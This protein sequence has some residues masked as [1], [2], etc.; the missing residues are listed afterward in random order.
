MY[1]LQLRLVVNIIVRHEWYHH[2]LCRSWA[3]SD[4]WYGCCLNMLG[5]A[6]GDEYLQVLSE[7]LN[8]GDKLGT[9]AAQVR[10]TRRLARPIYE[11]YDH[12]MTV[13]CD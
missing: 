3:S 7:E 1:W 6:Y 12:A 4:V 2:V 8:V 11:I 13:L 5:V 10:K 9:L